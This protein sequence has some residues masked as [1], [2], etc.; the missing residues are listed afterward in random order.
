MTTISIIEFSL[1]YDNMKIPLSPD[2]NT[3]RK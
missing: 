2:D 1:T 3:S